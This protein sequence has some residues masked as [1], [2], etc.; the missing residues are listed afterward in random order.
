SLL[1]ST[2]LRG[3]SPIIRLITRGVMRY[4]I[5]PCRHVFAV[6][7][8]AHPP[9]Q[10]RGERLLSCILVHPSNQL[11]RLDSAG[12]VRPVHLVCATF[13]D[14]GPHRTAFQAARFDLGYLLVR[15]PSP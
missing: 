3:C 11:S 15:S 13:A 6:R 12:V 9:A 10:P 2:P 1:S 8:T 7:Y 4:G 5:A 14:S